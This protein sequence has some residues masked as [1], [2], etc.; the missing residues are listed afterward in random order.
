MRVKQDHWSQP[1]FLR[2]FWCLLAALFAVAAPAA[3]QEVRVHERAFA[4]PVPKATT[5]Q[6]QMIVLAGSNDET[7]RS[8]Q[9]IA[10]YLEHL[11]L[12]GRDSRNNEGALKFFADGSSNGTT[13][14]DLTT[15]I[16]SFP[17]ESVDATERLNKL[18]AFYVE[19]LKDF[20]IS[21]AD[22]ARELNVVR[23]ERDWR[24]SGNPVILAQEDLRRFLYQGM[25]EE[26]PV[27]GTKES[28][29]AFTLDA[30][31]Q[32]QKQWYQ[33]GN[34]YFLVTGPV[35]PNAIKAIVDKHLG[36]LAVMPAPAR[37]WRQ[38]VR[39][40]APE[41]FSRTVTDPKIANDALSFSRL[42]Q[43]SSNDDLKSR[44]TQMLINMFLQSKIAGSPHSA[45]AEGDDPVVSAV[46]SASLWR[47]TQ[48]VITLS[49]GGV[50]EQGKSRADVRQALDAWLASFL[51][52]SLPDPVLDRLKRR[53]LNQIAKSREEPANATG[54][55]IGWLS[56][57]LSYED[58]ANWP[59]HIEAVSPEDIRVYLRQLDAPSRQVVLEQVKG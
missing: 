12:V 28:I 24:Y 26:H 47:P 7:D 58:L 21:D 1:A 11:V 37:P 6:F 20:A 35:E 17:A 30:A 40:I 32:F 29:A 25:P 52:T 38:D 51:K 22:A 50:P 43:A 48:K 14:S 42:F 59:K 19:R 5:I 23:Q 3:A 16:H 44:A 41:T 8:R 10:H 13:S 9:G 54:R 31:R 56:A 15:Y 46:T 2:G 49:L 27:I 36:A 45:L 39:T 34:V 55:L 53:V 57:G 18:F 33:L 4:I